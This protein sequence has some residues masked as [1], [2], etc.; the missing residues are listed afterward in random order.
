[1]VPVYYVASVYSAAGAWFILVIL[2]TEN[3]R[4]Q[5]NTIYRQQK[6]ILKHTDKIPASTFC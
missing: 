4:L 2:I 5:T 1:M 3:Y 6:R